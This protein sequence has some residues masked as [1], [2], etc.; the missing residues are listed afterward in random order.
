MSAKQNEPKLTYAIDASGKMV[1]I[2]NV[3]TRGIE[4]NCRC[5]KC[6]EELVAKLGHEGG[7]QAHFA[8]HKGSDCHGS[9]MTA[10][11]LLAQQIIEEEKV[12]ML[13]D[14]N[15][16]YIKNVTKGIKLESVSLEETISSRN[17]E[18][19]PDCI[20]YIQGKDNKLYRLL[21]EIFVTH[22]IDEN[23]NQIIQSLNEYCIEIDLSDL[24][25]SEFTRESLSKRLKEDKAD[26]KWICCPVF[27][28]Q[29]RKKLDE[30]E[31]MRLEYE[32]IEYEKRIAIESRQKIL[33]EKVLNWYS[34]GNPDIAAYIQN[35]ISSCP[36]DNKDNKVVP[37]SLFDDLVPQ[38]DFFYFIDN[39]PKDDISLEL[40]Y[41]LLYFYYIQAQSTNFG[42]LENRLRLFRNRR[43]KLSKEERIQLEELIS[44]R[45]VYILVRQ[46]ELRKYDDEKIIFDKAIKRYANDTKLRKEILMASSVIYHH[47]IGS[48]AIDFDELTKE[49]LIYHPMLANSYQKIVNNQ[50][51]CL[52]YYFH[53]ATLEELKK[54]VVNKQWAED[55]EDENV[56]TYLKECYSYAFDG[57]IKYK[58]Y[59]T[60]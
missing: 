32:Q 55:E 58:K 9:Y 45:I 42:K 46:R 14:Y 30:A 22:D 44:L 49:I 36:Y 38:N 59:Y 13:P 53:E 31:Q 54:F 5:P 34:G 21:I 43:D 41:V 23:K 3:V 19:R 35:D 18:I 15:G 25:D 7:R 2:R 26:R 8:H 33:H 24:I 39:S 12:L 11:H 56:D 1:Y 60:V 29:E 37:N 4:C 27:D 6:N 48:S 52:K 17:G 28:E 51:R 40:F 57:S 50:Q 47:I 20:G 10:L 16:L